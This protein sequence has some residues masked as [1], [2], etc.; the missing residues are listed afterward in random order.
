MGS[1]KNRVRQLERD[2]NMNAKHYV[3]VGVQVGENKEEAISRAAAEK[4]IDVA[5]LGMVTFH[6]EGSDDLEFDVRLN[7]YQGE[8]IDLQGAR[9]HEEWLE[10]L[11]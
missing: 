1:V 7:G 3:F 10:E 2:L 8:Y 6:Y 11:E 4:G 5:Q 9:S